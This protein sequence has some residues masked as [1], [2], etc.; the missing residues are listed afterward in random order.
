MPIWGSKRERQWS[1]RAIL[2]ET[3]CL[4]GLY[5]LVALWGLAL[6]REDQVGM[7]QTAWYPK[8]SATFGDLL[9]AIRTQLWK[10]QGFCPSQADPGLAEISPILL[11]R[12]MW[13]AC[14]SP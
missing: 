9:F 8:T 1:D 12:L 7:H 6:Y 3:P 14:V 4:F 11:S 5:S 2:R 13:S 10:A